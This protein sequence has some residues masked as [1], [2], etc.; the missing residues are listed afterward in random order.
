MFPGFQLEMEAIG[1]SDLG[2]L[3]A[4]T[5]E[6]K[7][8]RNDRSDCPARNDSAEF[9]A[10]RVFLRGIGYETGCARALSPR[11]AQRSQELDPVR[12]PGGTLRVAGARTVDSQPQRDF[13]S[14]PERH[15]GGKYGPGTTSLPM[16]F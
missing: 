7:D 1:S 8:L 15:L 16:Y 14:R 4:R 2:W 5:R 13:D 9:R 11:S 12:T 3:P 10:G 6:L